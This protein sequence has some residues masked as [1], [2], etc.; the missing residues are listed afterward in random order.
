MVE[1]F[2]HDDMMPS[3]SDTALMI[4]FQLKIL[5]L[6]RFAPLPSHH[7]PKSHCYKEGLRLFR[8]EVRN[9]PTVSWN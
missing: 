7:H 8:V 2:I 6:Y 5:K 1:Q 3:C 4:L 9:V